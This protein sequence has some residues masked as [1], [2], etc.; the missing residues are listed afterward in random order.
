MD[1]LIKKI[2]QLM[3][4]IQYELSH[5]R[6]YEEMEEDGIASN[7]KCCGMVGGDRTTDYTAEFCLDCPY[8]VPI[9]SQEVN[10][11]KTDR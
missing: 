6:C 4:K 2:K 11:G 7:G 5:E 10:D 3:R 8:F 9:N 1:R